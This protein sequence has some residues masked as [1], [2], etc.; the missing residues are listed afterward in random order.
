ML[1]SSNDKTKKA[2]QEKR[3]T[4][5]TQG[6]N[7]KL[8]IQDHWTRLQWPEQPACQLMLHSCLEE[9]AVNQSTCNKKWFGKL[10]GELG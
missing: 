5:L 2:D 10:E 1:V 8:T 9:S 7:L 4:G 3:Q 6:L